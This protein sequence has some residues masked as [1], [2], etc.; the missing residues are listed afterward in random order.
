MFFNLHQKTKIGYKL[1][2]DADLGRGTSSHQ[3]HIGLFEDTLNFITN[4]QQQSFAQFIYNDSLK[5]LLSFLDP[6]Q[7]PD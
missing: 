4:F 2:T 6:I 1:L 3:T 7:N 5:E